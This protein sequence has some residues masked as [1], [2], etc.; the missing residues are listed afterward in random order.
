MKTIKVI[1][2]ESNANPYTKSISSGIE[3]LQKFFC[4][5]C[6]IENLP[7]IFLWEMWKLAV[8]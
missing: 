7:K 2:K 6:G 1:I 8:G 5:K 4:G 3:N